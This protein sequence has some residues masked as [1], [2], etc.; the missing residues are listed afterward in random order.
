LVPD[1][2]RVRSLLE[3]GY[4]PDEVRVIGDAVFVCAATSYSAVK[5][6]NAFIERKLRVVATTRV[7]TTIDTAGEVVWCPPPGA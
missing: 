5:A 3:P 7:Y 6:H 2:E 1:A 4:D